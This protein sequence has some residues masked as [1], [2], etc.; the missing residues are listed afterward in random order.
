MVETETKEINGKI[1][2]QMIA[3]QERP[4]LMQ[5]HKYESPLFPI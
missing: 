1:N 3:R 2:C 5:R 4:E